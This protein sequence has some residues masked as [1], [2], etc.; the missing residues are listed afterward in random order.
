MLP[1][2][3]EA[4]RAKELKIPTD[5][6]GEVARIRKGGDESGDA[7]L[8]FF[9]VLRTRRG[10]QFSESIRRWDFISLHLVSNKI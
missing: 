8:V 2:A 3:S 4:Q 5:P 1:G 7:D 6:G 10:N 9:L